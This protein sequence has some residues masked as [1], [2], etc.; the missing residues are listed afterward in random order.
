MKITVILPVAI[1]SVRKRLCPRTDFLCNPTV[2]QLAKMKAILQDYHQAIK[3]ALLDLESSTESK[4]A[5]KILELEAPMVDILKKNC[6]LLT[7]IVAIHSRLLYL[8]RKDL[9]KQEVEGQFELQHI[10]RGVR[11]TPNFSF[12]LR[13]RF[14]I[15][16]HGET[17]S[18]GSKWKTLVC[19]PGGYTF[20]GVLINPRFADAYA[21]VTLGGWRNEIFASEIEELKSSLLKTNAERAELEKRKVQVEATLKK[22]LYQAKLNFRVDHFI[23]DLDYLNDLERIFA[24]RPSFP[25]D[26]LPFLD[27]SSISGLA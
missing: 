26:V 24:K 22:N 23:K 6:I 21:K 19:K 14:P 4:L 18:N 10:Q 20:T 5:K 2:P 9:E 8:D 17:T 11:P 13:V 16:Q 3:D 25:K 12:N 1:T 15:R 27:A 7:N